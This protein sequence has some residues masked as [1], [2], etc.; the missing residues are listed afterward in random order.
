MDDANFS[1]VSFN[2]EFQEW[3]KIP[4]SK[5]PTKICKVPVHSRTRKASAL[6]M[7]VS[8]TW[9]DKVFLIPSMSLKFFLFLS[10]TPMCNVSI[11][12]YLSF[13]FTNGPIIRAQYFSLTI[14]LWISHVAGTHACTFL[15]LQLLS[16]VCYCVGL[17]SATMNCKTF[18]WK[19][20][21]WRLLR[22]LD[23]FYLRLWSFFFCCSRSAPYFPARTDGHIYSS[24]RDFGYAYVISD[25]AIISIAILFYMW[26]LID[27]VERLPGWSCDPWPQKHG[28]YTHTVDW[29][30]IVPP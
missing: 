19:R 17:L 11:H 29:E 20:I 16:E 26:L 1:K 5:V 8:S 13:A 15:V 6:T 21:E 22:Y 3:Q 28:L 24:L 25:G 18:P 7:I 2:Q 9:W 10:Y 14:E 27:I 23:G 12:K 30:S 4:P